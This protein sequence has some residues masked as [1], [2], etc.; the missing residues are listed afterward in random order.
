MFNDRWAGIEKLILEQDP[1][2]L[3]ALATYL[4]L[5]LAKKWLVKVVK[6]VLTKNF[7]LSAYTYFLWF[8]QLI[9]FCQRTPSIVGLFQKYSGLPRES[10][11]RQSMIDKIMLEAIDLSI[12]GLAPADILD[13]IS[14]TWE[15]NPFPYDCQEFSRVILKSKYSDNYEAFHMFAYLVRNPGLALKALDFTGFLLDL[16]SN[17]EKYAAS[18]TGNEWKA[19]SGYLERFASFKFQG[20][21]S[22]SV[23]I[24]F[25]MA[26]MLDPRE[27]FE[28][29][30][31][32]TEHFMEGGSQYDIRAN[33]ENWSLYNKTLGMLANDCFMLVK[34]DFSVEACRKLV[35]ETKMLDQI[36]LLELVQ[37]L[38]QLDQPV[39][40][41]PGA[42]LKRL[43]YPMIPFCWLGDPQNWIGNKEFT[44]S[45]DFDSVIGNAERSSWN[46]YVKNRG[47]EKRILKWC[48]A[49]QTTFPVSRNC[50]IVN[51]LDSDFKVD[52]IAHFGPD[53]G[54]TFVL[55]NFFGRNTF[56]K[57]SDF[58]K[59]YKLYIHEQGVSPD[60]LNEDLYLYYGKKHEITVFGNVFT[61]TE[62]LKVRPTKLSLQ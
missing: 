2:G 25:D 44:A 52:K 32:L 47:Q 53:H 61:S 5:D 59:A 30:N 16:L 56:K 42:K 55:D 12:N 27:N 8:N 54:F 39:H 10:N 46:N 31:N 51:D 6:P 21:R 48:N 49:F 17:K 24:V 18:W 14:K 35:E 38:D 28:Y 1:N 26:N 45:P 57:S 29:Y 4:K 20:N 22:L 34:G 62:Q 41:D 13:Q 11:S 37:L 40:F 43:N 7:K 19:I 36:P 60:Y 58:S 3:H 15:V 50:Y 23:S 33:P 9:G